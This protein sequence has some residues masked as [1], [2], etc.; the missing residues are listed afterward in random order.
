MLKKVRRWGMIFCCLLSMTA[1]ILAQTPP[2]YPQQL[3]D[4]FSEWRA[5]QAPAVHDGVPDYTAAAMQRQHDELADWQR[6]LAAIDTSGWAIAHQIDYI[7]IWA[8]MNGLDFAHRVKKPWS[9]DPAF[10]VWFYPGLTDVPEREGP[11]IHGAIEWAYF[12]QPLSKNDAKEIAAR[13]RK[14]PA[15]FKQARQNLTGNARDLWV[16]STRTI[17]EQSKDLARFAEQIAEA[18]PDLAAAAREAQQAS[19]DFAEW[20]AARAD[21]KTGI[22][23]VG[24]EN[25]TWNLKKVHL[26]P[27]T[28]EEEVLLMQRELARAHS[29]L[30]LEEHR[31][32]HLPKL[33]N[34]DN[35]EE[36]ERL[37][38]DAVTEYVNF[39][40]EQEILT[41]KPYTE[42]ALRA[43]VNPF[44]PADGLRGF[45]SEITYRD[46]IIMRTHDYHWIE[47]ARLREEPHASPIRRTP[48]LY[49]IFDAR[50]EG[51]ATAVE[52]LMMH[53]G[54]LDKRPRSRELIWILLAQRCAR[55]L[56]GLYQHGLEKTFD[57]A[58]KF[59]SKWTPWGLLPADGGT[60]QFEEQFY[61]Q[62]PAY[63]T[64]Y[65][66]GK[67]EIDKLIAEY[68]RQ[69]DGQFVLKE[70]M[71]D[72]NNAGVIPVSLIYWEL[73]GDKSML[74]AALAD[75]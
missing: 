2:D 55:G 66:I 11:N 65:V 58:T 64:S 41:I 18:Y 25:Y 69:R 71:D 50:S 14:A 74:N 12:P 57:E 54:F 49:N 33:K 39:L 51:M 7:L 26:L 68:A 62:Q 37:F 32:R 35:A 15:V 61:L 42:P 9:R 48:L 8:E 67:L 1:T 3:A 24:K 56:G 19:D 4:F 60:I 17:R 30:R 23:G 47:L 46:P 29:A 43:R 10:Y 36:Y 75:E 16:T 38:N 34:I 6:R 63:G 59:A 72:F 45:F 40:T 73:T 5:F 20:L 44:T 13:L 27:Y 52:E 28:W 22:S 53:A 31:N 21:S 70:F